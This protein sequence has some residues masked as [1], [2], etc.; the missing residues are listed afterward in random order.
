MHTIPMSTQPPENTPGPIDQLALRYL[1]RALDSAHPTDE[2]FVMNE[3]ENQVIGKV[4]RQT[5]GMAALLGIFGVVSLYLPQYLWPA[6][7]ASNS[8]TLFGYSVD[9]PLITTLYAILL[10]YLEVYALLYINLRAV[11]YVMAV[12]QFPRQH[13]A[14][15]ERHLYALAEAVRDGADKG[16]LRYGIDPY[17]GLPQWGL[18]AFFVVNQV[19]AVISSF[20]LKVALRPLA[21]RFVIPQVINLI[22]LPVYAFWNVWA[23]NRVIHEAKIRVMAPL[24]I[25]E[26]V[27]DLYEEWRHNEAFCA[28][29]P[30]ALQY[31]AVLKRQYNY[32]HLL[33]TETLMDRFGLQVINPTGRFL[34]RLAE[35]PPEVRKPLER[36]VI[37][38]VLIDGNLSW[39]EKRRLRQLKDRSWL[40]YS[41][42]DI[43]QIGKEY[44][45]G[46]GLWV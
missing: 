36:L 17:L 35:A 24:T 7:F 33:L 10:V 19:K 28:L 13:D 1:R 38:G 31:V 22:G 30:E 40:S 2:P 16:L 37:F 21:G 12:C 23:S 29:I 42:A 39:F 25:R 27:D 11:R 20:V 9:L 46:R 4:R 45:Q 6:F 8:A 43:E 3:L 5:L 32:A 14:Q 18:T 34:D 15:Y 44:Y 41:V 26:F